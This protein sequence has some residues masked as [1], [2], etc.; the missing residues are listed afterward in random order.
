MN[1][2]HFSEIGAYI[3]FLLY[4]HISMKEVF[5]IIEQ[6]DVLLVLE[7]CINVCLVAVGG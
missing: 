7:E 6:S 4:Y 1:Q 3:F 5:I 2:L